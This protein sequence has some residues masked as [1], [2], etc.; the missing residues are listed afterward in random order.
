MHC[1]QDV[2]KMYQ[3]KTKEALEMLKGEERG[4]VLKMDHVRNSGNGNDKRVRDILLE[5]HPP[6][7][8]KAAIPRKINQRK[9]F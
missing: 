5:K 9:P 3:G 2:E 7:K 6:G 4:G 1:M 8:P